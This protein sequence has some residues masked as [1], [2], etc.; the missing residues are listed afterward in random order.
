LKI[1]GGITIMKKVLIIALLAGLFA[2]PVHAASTVSFSWTEAP[3]VSGGA[4]LAG[5][6]LYQ[7]ATSGQ[8]T[9]GA[10]SAV[11]TIPSTSTTYT[12][13]PVADGTWF[14]VITAYDTTGNESG[15]SN[16]VT[17]GLVTV[18]P[19]TPGAFTITGTVRVVPAGV[20]K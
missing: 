8:Y 2:V 20:T 15:P 13:T 14:W 4:T 9:Y 3:P 6:R 19:N 1:E 5:F 17:A 16:E 12:L 7:S 10:T 18:P 11:A